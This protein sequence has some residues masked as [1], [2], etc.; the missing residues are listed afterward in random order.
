MVP[1]PSALAPLRVELLAT[2]PAAEWATA[3]MAAGAPAGVL[4]DVAGA[5]Q[6]ATDL[7]L[8]PVVTLPRPDGSTVRL[9]RNPIRLSA[10]PPTY[11]CAPPRLGDPRGDD[12]KPDDGDSR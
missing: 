8:E 5:F 9:P 10:T 1:P 7:G 11:R 12:S 4:D 3:C 6:P 2:R